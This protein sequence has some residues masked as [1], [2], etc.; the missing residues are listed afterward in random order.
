M[1]H[2][3][4]QKRV[5]EAPCRNAKLA[6]DAYGNHPDPKEHFTVKLF[7][8]RFNK[9]ICAGDDFLVNSQAPLSGHAERH[10]QSM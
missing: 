1:N 4:M 2:E 3:L 6:I 7:E 5:P 8:D 10:G 9:H